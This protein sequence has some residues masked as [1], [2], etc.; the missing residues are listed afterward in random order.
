MAR[1]LTPVPA[2]MPESSADIEF[3]WTTVR[4]AW[5]ADLGMSEQTRA[6]F[7]ELGHRFVLSLAGQ[8]R[9]SWDDVDA[10]AC[11]AFVGAATRTGG[12]P[13][14]GTQHTRRAAVRAIFRTLR[15]HGLVA[16]DPTLDE[17]IPARQARDYRPLRDD[18]IALGRA[19]CRLGGG[20]RTLARAV[21]WALAETGAG[22]GE[23]PMLRVVDLDHPRTPTQLTIP[24]SRRFAARTVLLTDWGATV[25]ARHLTATG[26]GPDMPLAYEPRGDG[27]AYRGQ[28]SVA[29]NLTRVLDLAGLRRDPRVRARSIRGWA[30]RRAYDD[31]APLEQVAVLL[32]C[33]SLD[34]AAADI[35]LAWP[36]PGTGRGGAS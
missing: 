27:G 25:L 31:G 6:R 26:A 23:I 18:E 36:L 7:T 16:G 9:R 29:T 35:G 1:R 10:A 2:P 13:R 20:A 8:G 14:P 21:A 4:S 28:A 32:G 17:P 33:R 12:V 15:A 3:G 22:T 11:A 5:S 24:E 30:G 34:T 19:A